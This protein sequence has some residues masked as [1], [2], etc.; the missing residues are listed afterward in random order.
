MDLMFRLI[1]NRLNDQIVSN[2]TVLFE[3]ERSK[4]F[5]W[6]VQE[7][8]TSL[9]SLKLNTTPLCLSILQDLQFQSN[10]HIF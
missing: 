2:W 7:I 4:K 5:Q 10:N 8:R 9:L 6:T 3:T 1:S